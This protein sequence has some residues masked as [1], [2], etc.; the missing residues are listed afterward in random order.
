MSEDARPKVNTN[1]TPYNKK[2]PQQLERW[3]VSTLAKL[4][5]IL[6]QE[7]TVTGIQFY[8]DMED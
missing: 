4:R 3:I 8:N 2:I 6:P 7:N 1:Q 5:N